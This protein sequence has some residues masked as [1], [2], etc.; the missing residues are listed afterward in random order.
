MNFIYRSLILFFALIAADAGIAQVAQVHIPRIEIMPDEPS[1]YNMRDWRSVA[2]KYDSF[3]YDIH[4]TG[5]YLPLVSIRNNGNN[6]PGN[7]FFSMQTYV[8]SNSTTGN[9]AINSMPS[10]VGATL[11]G[12]DKSDQF[13]ENWILMSQDFYNKKNGENIYLNGT[14]SGSG[15][16][17]WYDMMPNIFFYQLADLY[18]NI[19]GEK[20]QQFLS[21]ADKML[22]AVKAMGGSDR[23]WSKPNMNYRAWSFKTMTP[24]AEG[25]IEPEAAGAFAW[26][27]YNAYLVTGNAEYLKGAEWSLDFLHELNSNPSYELQL[28]YGTYTAARINAELGT[29]YNVEKLVNWSFDR[30]PLRGWGTIVGKWG[31]FDVS[32]L[33]GEANDNGNDYAFQLNGVQQAAML[34]PMVRYDKRFARAIGKWVLNMANAT[35]LYF[36]GFLPSHLQDGSSWAGQYDPDRII[37]HEALREKWNGNSPFSTGDAVKGGW[38]GTNLSLYST[39]SIGYLGAILEKTNVE[40][41]LRLD[42][43]RTDFFQK[44]S[45][46]TY[47]YY[48]PYDDDRQVSIDL[49]AG[50]RSVYDA[51]TESW[52]AEEQSGV[53]EITIPA[54]GALIATI[55]P[56]GGVQSYNRNRFLVDGIVVDY[57]Q[58]AVQYTYAPRILS[59]APEKD[60]VEFGKATRIFAR[61]LDKDS[62][63][64]T[65]DWQA[66]SGELTG[67]GSEVTWTAP[68]AEGYTTITLIVSDESGNRDTLSAEVYSLAEINVEPEIIR[69][70]TSSIHVL[71]SQSIEMQ[72]VAEDA[73]GD[74]LTYQWSADAGVF[75]DDGSQSTGW[76]A[77]GTEGI[78]TITLKV[79]DEGGLSDLATVDIL[80]K[81]FSSGPAGDLVA[82]YPF[83]N[84][85]LDSTDYHHDGILSGP[86]FVNDIKDRPKSAL[87]FDG[88]NDKVTVNATQELN[89]QDAITVSCWVRP[90]A[91]PDRES[92]IVSHGSW[93]N[94]WKLSVTP[95]GRPR[96]TVNT[97]NTITDLD[98]VV[99]LQNGNAAM[100]TVCYDGKIMTMYI[101]GQL[102]SFKTQTGK[103]KQ[104]N[105]PVLIGQMTPDEANYNFRG[106][107]DE[108]MVFN[109]AL[110]PEAIEELYQKSVLKNKDPEDRMSQLTLFP[111]PAKEEIH[112]QLNRRGINGRVE[113]IDLSGR[114]VKNIRV[115][116]T[117]KV[118]IDVS[119]LNPGVY[120]IRILSPELTG[121]GQ[122]VKI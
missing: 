47:L 101:D 62:D 113:V 38:A 98:A 15:H 74:V 26:L 64:L 2:M 102:V 42:L 108:V 79:T 117:E 46:P 29:Q 5:Q 14:N 52:I 103:I 45:Y 67:N 1:P 9:E 73:N 83:S 85:V 89:F 61:A 91:L 70:V 109:Y 119:G 106:L 80:V 33:V 41:I 55:T 114:V 95:E 78:Y 59:L 60:T 77:P 122:W 7:K 76:V 25:V 63:N 116:S 48:N 8:G 23:P 35:R 31:G 20:D 111:N 110:A 68:Q 75:T 87:A 16:D 104:T 58:T 69:V 3:V 90:D 92:F 88:V 51:V 71:P 81:E 97:T 19:G 40:K 17:W 100:I 107:I 82:W 32:G 84:N 94:R 99:P 65:Y 43:N 24:L 22:A 56:A 57:N 27:L 66:E 10:L 93:Q 54:N 112:I 53:I 21:I 30:G 50:Q 28:P 39:S 72:G 121:V 118:S 37:G 6:Y 11:V 86:L 49:G 44:K 12:I 105:I 36:P 18:P 120:L 4:K 13:G 115:S 96:W 34:V